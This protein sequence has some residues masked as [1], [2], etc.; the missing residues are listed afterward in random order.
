V[1]L[2]CFYR[3]SELLEAVLDVTFAA[4]C[5]YRCLNA[6]EPAVTHVSLAF[7]SRRTN[8]SSVLH[9]LRAYVFLPGVVSYAELLA[10]RDVSTS[11]N[12][13]KWRSLNTTRITVHNLRGKSQ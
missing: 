9:A 7:F 5:C 12:S 13:R 2:L 6:I 1:C 4:T 10:E 11:F 3:F 8:I